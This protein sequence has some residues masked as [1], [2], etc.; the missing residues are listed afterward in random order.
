MTTNRD[1]LIEKIFNFKK[2]LKEKLDDPSLLK[3]IIN[4]NEQ[5]LEKTIHYFLGLVK[6]DN[7]G[8]QILSALETYK[9]VKLDKYEKKDIEKFKLYIQFFIE[10][11]K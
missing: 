7:K 3:E 8:D 5:N 6:Y 10:M 2:F 11:M 1:L 4:I 9:E